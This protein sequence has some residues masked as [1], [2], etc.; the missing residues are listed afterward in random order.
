MQTFH[1]H[2]ATCLDGKPVYIERKEIDEDVIFEVFTAMTVKNPVFWDIKASS[3]LT[4]NTLLLHYRGQ[5]VN[6]M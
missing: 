1:L 4:G 6:A 3:Y 5:P 2:L